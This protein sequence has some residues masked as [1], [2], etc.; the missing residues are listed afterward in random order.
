MKSYVFSGALALVLGACAYEPTPLPI[1]ADQQAAVNSSVLS[2]VQYQDPL[3]GYTYRAPTGPRDWRS[4][5]EEQ[6]EGN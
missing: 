2:P 3:A 6:T 5:N 4:V 1:V